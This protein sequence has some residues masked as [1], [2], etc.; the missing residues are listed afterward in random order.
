LSAYTTI[1]VPNAK[2][3]R[4][5]VIDMVNSGVFYLSDVADGK[6]IKGVVGPPP[7]Y[8]I[9]FS[10]LASGI[11]RPAGLLFDSKNRLLV[12]TDTLNA[13]ILLVNTGNG[14]V[15]T[16]KSTSLANFHS[17]KED[18]QGNY[19]TTNHSDSYLYRFNSTFSDSVKL[20]GY[21]Q[22][23]GMYINTAQDMMVL[24]CTGCGKVYYN[25]L[26][27]ITPTSTSGICPGD[28]FYQ[29]L[30]ISSQGIGTYFSNNQFVVELSDS[31]GSFDKVSTLGILNSDKV[32]QSIR[33]KLPQMKYGSFHNVRVRAT[34]PAIN[35]S[36]ASFSMNQTPV[37]IAYNKPEVTVCPGKSLR[38]GMNHT[39]GLTY[40]WGGD[41]V[42]NVYGISNPSFVGRDSGMFQ[43]WVDVSNTVGCHSHD[44]VKILVNSALSIVGMDDTMRIC[45]GDTVNIGVSGYNYDFLWNHKTGLSD[46]TISNPRAFPQKNTRF[47]VTFSDT[48][49]ACNGMDSVE[50]LV[51]EK[52]LTLLIPDTSKACFGDSVTLNTYPET[53]VSFLW[54]RANG[55]TLSVSYRTTFTDLPGNYMVWLQ[56]ASNER[57]SCFQ[58]DSLLVRFLPEPQKP[59]ITKVGST[60]T[61]SVTGMLYQWFLNDNPLTGTNKSAIT[62][63]D[64]GNYTV[65][66]W[67]AEGCPVLSGP[68]RYTLGTI[69]L[70]N[71]KG[72]IIYPNPT[73][74][75]IFMKG[76]TG[77]F[78]VS[79]Y[80]ISD[81]FG[82]PLLSGTG[83]SIIGEGINI[84][85]LPP[86]VYI[87]NIALENQAVSEIRFIKH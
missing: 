46:S 56:V 52:P 70:P 10:V 4:S 63:T 78:Q 37:A 80:S 54:Y 35:G 25:L 65:K 6:I 45:Q 49:G 47:V 48:S 26:H 58:R 81:V 84:A 36:T 17:I 42:L 61:S 8:A 87:I 83:N 16:L 15:S 64:T 1:D 72:M 20:T 7:F 28:S 2:E 40:K 41:S 79:S 82:R 85:E 76:A 39:S 13:S 75:L 69:D 50:V 22:P 44:T 43:V 34:H 18:A 55:D 24:C 57:S 51:Y 66:V 23:S 86:G 19:Y 9:S 73:S 67:D 62:I 5:G 21:Y 38:I 71:T 3:I 14:N 74:Q 11:S 60:L 32:P 31:M 53:D 12:V 59:V 30:N 68:Y 77:M 33:C 29:N 27:I